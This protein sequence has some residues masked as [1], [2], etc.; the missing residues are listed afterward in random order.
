MAL[1][2]GRWTHQ[3]DG[4]LSVF[5]IGMTINK[6][7]RPD[8]WV[9]V[10][11]AMGPMLTELHRN[12]EWGFRGYRMSLSLRGP[13]LVQYWDSTEQVYAY[14]SAAPAHHRPA[15]SAFNRRARS[16][17]GAVGIWHETFTVAPGAHESISVDA[18]LAGLAAATAAVP[19]GER[20]HSARQRMQRLGGA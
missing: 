7:W 13:V 3:H 17:A 11:Q 12:R 2:R 16:A 14:A 18:P 8:Q 19:V 15:W 4:G 5:L 10:L 6:P 9:P 20:T 1:Q